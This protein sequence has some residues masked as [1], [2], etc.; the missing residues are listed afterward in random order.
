MK[1]IAIVQEIVQPT[2]DFVIV[3]FKSDKSHQ[4][5][6][7]FISSP[8]L[9]KI[10]KYDELLLDVKFRSV[11]MRDLQ[12][13]KTYDTQLYNEMAIEVTDMMRKEYK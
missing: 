10:R 5:F 6:Q 9:K 4:G 1:L 11:V 7:I 3:K 12:G 8:Y 13:A 2:D